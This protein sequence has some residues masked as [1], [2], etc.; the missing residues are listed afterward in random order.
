M[1]KPKTIIAYLDGKY[2]CDVVYAALDNNKMVDEMKR[3]LVEANPGH[4]VE[5]KVEPLKER[6]H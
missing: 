3:I 6:R 2:L 1:W 4:K 5:F